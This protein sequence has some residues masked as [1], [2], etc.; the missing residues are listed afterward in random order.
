MMGKSIIGLLNTVHPQL[1]SPVGQGFSKMWP[2]NRK[3]KRP[4]GTDGER[5]KYI[6]IYKRNTMY[7]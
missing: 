4:M 6:Y 2:D 3:L 1:S 7:A 5:K